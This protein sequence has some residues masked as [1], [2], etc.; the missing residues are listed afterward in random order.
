MDT[1]RE[2]TLRV[3]ALTAL[4]AAALAVRAEGAGAQIP[5][6]VVDDDTQVASIDFRFPEGQSFGKGELRGLLGLTER[7]GL[8]G[9][10]RVL[11]FIP[12][13]PDVGDHP[14]EPLELQ[15]DVARLRNHYDGFL[16]TEISYEVTYDQEENTVDV[17]FVVEEGRP[18]TVRSVQVRTPEGGDPAELLPDSLRDA[19][20][21]EVEQQ[22]D[23]LVGDRY[24]VPERSGL[25]AD[26]L[27][28]WANRGWAF[29][30]GRAEAP[31]DS[32]AAAVDLILTLDPGPRARVAEIEVEGNESIEDELILR[33]LPFELGDWYSEQRV[34]EG[35]R[36]LFG[37]D[38]FRLVLVD[39][40]PQPR[41]ST[42]HVRIRIQEGQPRLVAGQ[43]GYESSG[44]GISGGAEV[45]HRNFFGGARTLRVT[46]E[47]RTGML[48]L[49][50]LQER[51]YGLT[52]SYR[53]PIFFDPRLSLHVAPYGRYRDN[54]IDRSWEA[55]VES[56]LVFEFSPGRYLSLLHRYASRRVL[57]FR[58]GS[59]GS[60]DLPT[61][62]AL[63][64]GGAVDSIGGQ[65]DR[66]TF[67]VSMTLG[68]FDPSIRRRALQGQPT[69]EV[70]APSALNA[71]EYWKL[72][73]PVTGILPVSDRV[74]LAGEVRW[75]RVFPFGKTIRGDS[76][77]SI[78]AEIQLRDVLLRAGGTG[79][80]RGWGNGLLG[81][82]SMNLLFSVP[83]GADTLAVRSDGYLPV[84]GL[85]RVSAS[86][87]VR[88]PFPGLSDT[89]GTH[90]FLDVG[91]VWTPDD[92]F[93]TLGAGGDEKWYFGTGAGVDV[94]TI[95][96]PIR[97]SVGY[98]LNPSPL[99]LRDPAEVFLAIQ[100]GRPLSS[101]ETSGLRRFHLHVSLGVS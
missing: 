98:K 38:L 85:S 42:V 13:V 8:V 9:L 44:A 26:V 5:Y 36:R 19:W 92:R 95:A 47:F 73:V 35:Q 34:S 59:R 100:E 32:A 11:S 6:R 67:A 96:G 64:A 79:S 4:L 88:L 45:A 91:R 24:S 99:D 51:E 65:L 57:D 53:R 54:F 50:P 33:T 48:A 97:L 72:D 84:G 81:P 29:A 60:I 82:K 69:I 75:G 43:V 55:G 101:V 52:L 76:I 39:T 70:T 87:E 37:L 31:L 21:E 94:G 15:R 66:S 20:R 3:A 63:V 77:A 30:T 62:L 17:V 23:A 49:G 27:A 89:W 18:I 16:D 58:L 71:I 78:V 12:L 68:R 74:T 46:G 14:F 22:R 56:S 93:A 41:D 86:G 83:E 7:G 10:R 2:S 61:L 1:A 40:P 90:V 25:E 28:W 80:V